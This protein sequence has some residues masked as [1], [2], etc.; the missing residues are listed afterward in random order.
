MSEKDI[1]SMSQQ[2]MY[3]YGANKKAPRP[4]KIALHGVR[5]KTRAQL[6]KV[7]G[8]QNGG[9]HAFEDIPAPYIEHK[10]YAKEV[11]GLMTRELF[12]HLN[13]YAYDLVACILD[14]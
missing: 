2:I 3:C 13:S 10:A 1:K 6:N 8:F 7:A 5:G 4:L 11:T 12:F 9:W 14:G